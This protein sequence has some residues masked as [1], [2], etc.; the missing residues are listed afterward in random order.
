VLLGRRVEP[1]LACR[2]C[3]LQPMGLN[4]VREPSSLPAATYWRRRFIALLAGM[5]VLALVAWA[6]SGAV[7]ATR[8]AG[9]STTHKPPPH[10]TVVTPPASSPD[11]SL[12][13][14][15]SPPSSKTPTAQ[16][17]PHPSSSNGT[18]GTDKTAGRTPVCSPG[19]VVLSLFSS[20]G[21]YSTGQDAQFQIDVVSTAK[22]SCNFDVGAGHVVL[23][24]SKGTQIVWT[25]AQ[26]AE[27]EASLI[28]TLHRGVPTIVPM[29]WT[30]RRSSA[31][32]PVP[33][34]QAGR[35]SYTAVATDG[36]LRSSTV[37][38]RLS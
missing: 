5:S 21:S 36:T 2:S 35:G 15:G 8:A 16:K 3:I 34:A 4:T 12:A 17:T 13:A 27:G 38:F 32:C 25:S 11:P 26:C 19:Y 20:Q 28:A 7:N 14:S 9:G 33:G 10:K 31:G 22:R 6:L 29:T 30:G 37:N 24:I 23:Q 18:S 1:A